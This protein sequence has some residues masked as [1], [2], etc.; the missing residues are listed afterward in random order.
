MSS[1]KR[2]NSPP[3]ASVPPASQNIR[4][5]QLTGVDESGVRWTKELAAKDQQLTLVSQ[6]NSQLRQ[7]LSQLEAEMGQLSKSLMSKETKLHAKDRELEKKDDEVRRLLSLAQQDEG[8][9]RV[10]E[11]GQTQNGKLLSLLEVHEEKT[12]HLTEERDRLTEE[13]RDMRTMFNSK[14]QRAANDEAELTWKLNELQRSYQKLRTTCSDLKERHTGFEDIVKNTEREAKAAVRTIQE[15]LEQRRDNQY[16]ALIKVQNLEDALRQSRDNEERLRGERAAF[17]QRSDELQTRLESMMAVVHERDREAEALQLSHAQQVSEQANEVH[18]KDQG[19]S[20]LQNRID[21]LGQ[22]LLDMVGKHRETAATLETRNKQAIVLKTELIDAKRAEAD[23]ENEAANSAMEASKAGGEGDALSV[24]VSRLKRELTQARAKLD[25]IPRPAQIPAFSESSQHRA[26]LN[27]IKLHISLVH[28]AGAMAKESAPENPQR[29]DTDEQSSVEDDA[30][31]AS[32]QQGWLAIPQAAVSSLRLSDCAIEEC[33]LPE[34]AES[35]GKEFTLLERADLS[36]N[37]LTDRSL[38]FLKEF[39]L[40]CPRLAVLD[41][42]RNQLSIDGIRELSLFLE[43]SGLRAGGIRHVYVHRD[44]L[45]EAIGN[46]EK[47]TMSSERQASSQLCTVLTVD[48]RLNF[49]ESGK[50]QEA[51]TVS[52]CPTLTPAANR[53]LGQAE[54]LRDALKRRRRPNKQTH[55]STTQHRSKLLAGVYGD[56]AT[57]VRPAERA[58]RKEVGSEQ[59]LPAI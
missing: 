37:N 33:D 43:S 17:C 57:R 28:E 26:R 24:E 48:A 40:A 44:G 9:E 3:R 15:E 46:T 13:L 20:R 8:K 12:K 49:D 10:I 36:G 38:P 58:L 31:I 6:V 1:S 14:V 25:S 55:T 41:L 30:S 29:D 18:R 19:M 23:R 22:S 7:S 32:A 50:P 39:L 59:Q 21:E 53:N 34:L 35:L 16:A 2:G 5:P 45:I 51:Q 47:V 27:S 56:S 42:R 54:S 52:G 4:R 11:M